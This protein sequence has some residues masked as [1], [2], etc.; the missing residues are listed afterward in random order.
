L[1]IYYEKIPANALRFFTSLQ[2]ENPSDAN[3]YGLSLA[4]KNSG[5]FKQSIQQINILAR[6]YPK[7]L[8]I[9]TTKVEILKDA[10]KY[11]DALLLA[12]K[13]LEISPKNFPLSVTKS[14]LLLEMGEYFNSEEII[15]DQILRRNSNP[16]LWLLLS[17][18]QRASK[19]IIGYHQ[20]RAE[21]LLLLGRDEEA[22]NQLEFALKLT[23]N[24]FQISESILTKIVLIK[25]NINA[26]RNL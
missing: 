22:L 21:Y 14:K 13:F 18:I 1:K 9:N 8:F 20:S 5:N 17:E 6:K 3:L 10:K 24:N 12:N 26:S 23:K 7:N 4:N 2:N 16:D 15:R 11:D 19:N 25:E